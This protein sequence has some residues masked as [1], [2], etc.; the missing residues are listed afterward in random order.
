MVSIMT[1]KKRGVTAFT[2]MPPTCAESDGGKARRGKRTARP[3]I[4]FAVVRCAAQ[5]ARQRTNHI[6]PS[7]RARA[8]RCN[9]ATHDAGCERE[10]QRCLT[11]AH[12]DDAATCAAVAAAASAAATATA[13]ATPS[14]ATASKQT[15]QQ[16]ASGG[17]YVSNGGHTTEAC[18]LT[19]ERDS[20]LSGWQCTG[21]GGAAGYVAPR[22]EGTKAADGT[23]R[24]TYLEA[25]RLKSA[26]AIWPDDRRA[27]QHD[28]PSA[29]QPTEIDRP[30]NQRSRPGKTPAVPANNSFERG[31]KGELK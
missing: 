18:L 19:V 20:W 6:F 12:A 26:K 29:K 2:P 31:S 10:C 4:A 14:A 9:A 27:H 23:G 17:H 30:P 7:T 13:T 3:A 1:S 15:G 22:Q 28:Q 11:V 5:P 25:F 21:D 24:T 16:A 8:A